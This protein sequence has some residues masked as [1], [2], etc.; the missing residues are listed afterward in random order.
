MILGILSI[1][2]GL[3]GLMAFFKD[4]RDNTLIISLGFLLGGVLIPD[5]ILAFFEDED[6]EEDE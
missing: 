3:I 6:K 1:L 4:G 5:S 2:L